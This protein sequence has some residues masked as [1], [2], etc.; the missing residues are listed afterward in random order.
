MSVYERIADE[1]IANCGMKEAYGAY[2][3]RTDMILKEARSAYRRLCAIY[4][5]DYRLT[6]QCVISL[7]AAESKFQYGHDTW[8]DILEVMLVEHIT[9]LQGSCLII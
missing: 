3:Y 4:N 2:L 8:M 5:G 9:E 1:C 6:C 7:E